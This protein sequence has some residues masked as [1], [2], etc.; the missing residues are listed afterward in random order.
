MNEKI[1]PEYKDIHGDTYVKTQDGIWVNANPAVQTLSIKVDLEKF[2][3][4]VTDYDD[5]D[6][7]PNFT[8]VLYRG[9][10]KINFYDKYDFIGEKACDDKF[11]FAVDNMATGFNRH[12]SRY[13]NRPTAE[14]ECCV[15][16][17]P[18]YSKIG[19]TIKNPDIVTDINKN[20]LKQNY[21]YAVLARVPHLVWHCASFCENMYTDAQKGHLAAKVCVLRASEY[22]HKD[23]TRFWPDGKRHCYLSERAYQ[24]RQAK[25]K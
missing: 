22:V 23:E 8:S 15:A 4:M 7:G 11:G 20:V 18:E 17:V 10:T 2:I 24:M 5:M 19:G 9:A 1:A 12:F 25:T 6:D 14:M 21:K 16:Q 13:R 3:P